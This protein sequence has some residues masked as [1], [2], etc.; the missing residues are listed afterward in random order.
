MRSNVRSQKEGEHNRGFPLLSGARGRGAGRLP[1]DTPGPQGPGQCLPWLGWTGS[2]GGGS[3]CTDWTRGHLRTPVRTP[4]GGNQGPRPMSHALWPWTS[5]CT[6]CHLSGTSRPALPLSQVTWTL[7]ILSS[8]EHRSVSSDQDRGQ[9]SAARFTS[10]F[11][12]SP[13]P[14]PAKETH[15]NVLWRG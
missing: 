7:E 6:D 1:A 8:A 13:S 11:L 10:T 5:S 3:Y 14:G 15:K 12:G 2:P 9:A 4:G